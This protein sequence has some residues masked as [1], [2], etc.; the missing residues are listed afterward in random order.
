MVP[1]Q[2]IVNADIWFFFSF[3]DST[4]P[5]E[6]VKGTVPHQP[7]SSNCNDDNMIYKIPQMQASFVIQDSVACDTLYRTLN[8]ITIG[9]NQLFGEYNQ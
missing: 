7:G 3:T 9:R 5:A 8:D 1:L 2:K 4:C 6:T